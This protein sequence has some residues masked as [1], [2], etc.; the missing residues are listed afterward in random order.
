MFPMINSPKSA[1]KAVS[2]CRFP[3]NGVRGSDYGIDERCLSNFE[4]E[5]LVMCQVELEEG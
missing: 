2:Y 4:E 1:R 3:L 5:L